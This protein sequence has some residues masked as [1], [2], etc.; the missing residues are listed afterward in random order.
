M[1][2][3]SSKR[4]LELFDSH[5]KMGL[6]LPQD[7]SE[8]CRDDDQSKSRHRD[9]GENDD[10]GEAHICH[11]ISSRRFHEVPT[12]RPTTLPFSGLV[13]SVSQDQVC[14]NGEVV[15][16]RHGPSC[17]SGSLAEGNFVTIRIAKHGRTIRAINAG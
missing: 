2:V 7:D 1:R 13:P 11:L 6:S 14:C 17:A 15:G 9:D 16:Q 5:A 8:N 12:N 10:L 4:R 3:L